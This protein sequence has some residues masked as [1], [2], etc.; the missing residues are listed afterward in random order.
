MFF[1]W[2][3]LCYIHTLVLANERVCVIIVLLVMILL[4]DLIMI[5][6]GLS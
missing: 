3:G 1:C 2:N 5:N 4:F 6:S